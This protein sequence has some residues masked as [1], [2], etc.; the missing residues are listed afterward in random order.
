MTN[1]PNEKAPLSDLMVE[2]GVKTLKNLM[3]KSL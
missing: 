3:R 1:N 2:R